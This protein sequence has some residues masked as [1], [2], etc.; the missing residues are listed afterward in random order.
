[1]KEAIVRGKGKTK[2]LDMPLD[3]DK[4]KDLVKLP[5]LSKFYEIFERLQPLLVVNLNN[6]RT[7]IAYFF[8]IENGKVERDQDAW[9]KF[10]VENSYYIY[11]EEYKNKYYAA[12]KVVEDINKYLQEMG[13][14]STG[15][16][17]GYALELPGI[18]RG[19]RWE[20]IDVKYFAGK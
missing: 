16:F 9:E 15:P 13:F 2:A 11:S 12:K 7:E 4:L 1:M 10:V 8:V 17:R 6:R 18:K 14:E 20:E 3:E 19:K 5:D